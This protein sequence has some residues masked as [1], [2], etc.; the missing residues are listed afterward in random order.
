VK[1]KNQGT[2]GRVL[3]VEIGGKHFSTPARVVNHVEREHENL[4]FAN[5]SSG[6]I[7]QE[8]PPCEIQETVVDFDQERVMKL[9][10]KNGELVSEARFVSSHN[11]NRPSRLKISNIRSTE[12]TQWN[13][14]AIELLTIMQLDA[15]SLDLI[16][17][18]DPIYNDTQTFDLF[19][20]YGVA[21]KT[22]DDVGLNDMR[23]LPNLDLCREPSDLRVQVKTLLDMGIDAISL[24]HRPKSYASMQRVTRLLSDKDVWIH[25]S[26]VRKAAV[27]GTV[28]AIHIQPLYSID[29]ISAYKGYRPGAM[30]ECLD[31]GHLAVA[32]SPRLSPDMVSESIIEIKAPAPDPFS[33][34]A[35]FDASSL[36]MLTMEQHLALLGPDLNCRCFLCQGKDVDGFYGYALENGKT[37]IPKFRI[38]QTIH[39]LWASQVEFVNSREKILET[40]YND[41][42]LEK[43]LIRAHEYD[44]EGL[45][46]PGG[47]DTYQQS[48]K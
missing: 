26:G 1:L 11:R 13:R 21:R 7:L 30:T 18:P 22:L 16:S 29:S 39:E 36:G 44:I 14:D 17:V 35:R 32:S 38:H 10:N 27:D 3:E 20:A 42:L 45:V 48:L 9:L 5:Y 31:D 8:L 47:L 34:M 28:A 46:P 15:K 33:K 41:Y 23:V 25:L 6:L 24:R 40:G 37:S 12:G 43:D 19:D 2:S 4:Y